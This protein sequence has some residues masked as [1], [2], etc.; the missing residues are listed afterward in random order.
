LSDFGLLFTALGIL[1]LIN[2]IVTTIRFIA[3]LSN[4]EQ[5]NLSYFIPLFLNLSLVVWFSYL[6]NRLV[7]LQVEKTEN[8]IKNTISFQEETK[9]MGEDILN[10]TEQRAQTKITITGDNA[11]LAI[12]GSTVSGVTQTKTVEGNPD[13]VK[14]LALL[15]SFCEVK[16]NKEAIILAQNLTDEATKP[17]PN[18]G[19]IFELWNKI[20]SL[21]PEITSVLGI[22]QGIKTLFI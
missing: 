1:F 14:T 10:K 18:K 9:K 8:E 17:T 12:D 7:K 22:A 6:A 21:L 19:V 20:A 11:I 13:L 15:V 5:L 3:F 4:D 16:E 2:T